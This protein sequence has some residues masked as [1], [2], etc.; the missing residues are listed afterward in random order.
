[1][2]Q[3]LHMSIF[4]QYLTQSGTTQRAIAK[5]VSASPSYINELVKGTKSPSL[6]LAFA[7]ERATQ[8]AVPAASWG[9]DALAVQ[10]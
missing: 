4:A 10:P 9:S 6:K 2:C 8:G 7:I 3:L 5:A 1:M